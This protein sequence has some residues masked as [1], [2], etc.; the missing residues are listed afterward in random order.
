VPSPGIA[1]LRV[2]AAAV[3]FS[4][5]GAAIKACALDGWQVASL[6]SG[7][8]AVAILLMLSSS[9]RGWSARSALVGI[10]YAATLVLFVTATKLT[11]AA[12]TIFLQSTAPFYLVV[13]GPWLLRERIRPRDVGFLV[14]LGAGLLMFFV[15]Q[16]PAQATAPDPVRGNLLAAGSGLA[17]AFTLAGLRW[18]AKSEGGQH[19]AAALVVGNVLACAVAL[20]WALPLGAP[21]VADWATVAYLGVVQIGVAYVLLVGG[22]GEVP[23]L[24]ASLLLLVE[25]VLNPVWA[26]LVHG[27]RPSRFAVVGA[28]LILAATASRSVLEARA[29]RAAGRMGPPPG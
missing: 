2:V 10:G 17:W 18:L 12:N 1:R 15:G 22:L 13:L 26:W 20:P 3:V 28:V 6:R 11:T 25:P 14:L 8:A 9:R 23:A 16:E 27:E 7:I 19:G 21:T 4:T 29:A 24:E 5:G